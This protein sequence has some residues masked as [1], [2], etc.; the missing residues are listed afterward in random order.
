MSKKQKL[1]L[2]W[3]GKDVRPKLEPRI[4][5]ENPE[6]SF[7][8]EARVSDNDIFDNILIHGD[9][10]LALKALE[11][12]YAGKVKC[13]YIDPPYNTGSAF[14]HYDD[15]V[16]HSLWLGLMR[17]RLEILRQLLTDDGSLWINL[18]DNEVHYCK[19]MCDELFGRKNFLCDISWEK[20]YS[21]PPDTKDFGYIHD[22]I[23]V[24]R[25][26]SNFVR[27]LL[28]LTEDQTGRYKNPDND[29]RGSWKAMDYTCR[30]TAE[31]RPNLYY[32]VYQPNLKKEIWPKKTRV[33]AMSKDV[34]QKNVSENR[35]WWGVNGTNNVPALKNFFSEI[36]QG[37]M[38]MSLWKHTLAGH[39]QEAMKEMLSLYG[40]EVF[41]TPKPERLIQQVIHIATNPGDLV[42]DSFLGS[43][44]TAAVAHK[45]GR[46][47]IGIELGEHCYT[48]CIPRLQKVIKDE[49][50]GGITKAVNWQGGG[51]FRFYEL[52]PSLIREDAWGNPV[53][54]QD[55]NPEMLAEALCK[56]ENFSYA[57]SPETFWIHGQSSETDFIYVTTQFLT[58]DMLTHIA[59]ELGEKRSLLV[60]C[61]AH[62]VNASAFANITIKKIPKAVLEKCEWGKDDYSLAVENLPQAAPVQTV[63]ASEP[64]KTSKKT[65]PTGQ[66][67][68][69][70]LVK[71]EQS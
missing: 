39:N 2:T 8:A 63:S 26:T 28:P 1:E 23:L 43:G 49:D 50:S 6:L 33:W 58:Q 10:L 20:R 51:G 5:L 7:H 34:H 70:D 60:C 59:A 45:M 31:E 21:P 65:A 37:M 53:I 18:D 36:N 38:P 67:S 32:P 69:F 64:A 9:N 61:A 16:E 44:T 56:L 3:I 24:Y 30:F 66:S 4:L 46:R 68:L 42:L 40:N 55:F 54:N 62:S 52:G 35:I 29:P 22:H 13:I 12:E 19:V 57:P 14:E 11:Q 48:H 27:H 15:G 17:D 41:S 25:K 71:G 47:W